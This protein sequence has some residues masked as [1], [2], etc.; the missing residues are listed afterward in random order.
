MSLDGWRFQRIYRI[1][2]TASLSL[3]LAYRRH[4]RNIFIIRHA[5]TCQILH[6][7][8]APS[9][10]LTKLYASPPHH[11]PQRHQRYF[12]IVFCFN[13]HIDVKL[14][15]FSFWVIPSFALASCSFVGGTYSTFCFS[16]YIILVN[17]VFAALLAARSQLF[18]LKTLRSK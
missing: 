5:L 10:H 13:F 3:I 12:Q 7:L 11:S 16:M 8:Q 18:L 9:N 15:D 2:H 14:L 1:H 6:F 4:G 17:L